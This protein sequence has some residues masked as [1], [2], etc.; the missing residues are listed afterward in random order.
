MPWLRDL[1]F[2]NTANH[3]LL[4]PVN[5]LTR[6][7]PGENWI[8]RKVRV[9]FTVPNKRRVIEGNFGRPFIMD[10][11]CSRV[12]GETLAH[13]LYLTLFA[14]VGTQSTHNREGN[15]Y[16]EDLLRPYLST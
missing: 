6:L 4:S 12:F 11:R 8:E 5:I 7:F 14:I 15:H 2:L 9:S 1:L 10:S 13:Y 16:F 3:S